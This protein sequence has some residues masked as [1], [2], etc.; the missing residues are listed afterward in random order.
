MPP[1]S[2]NFTQKARSNYRPATERDVGAGAPA[3]PSLPPPSMA[4]V[5]RR[6]ESEEGRQRQPRQHD[7]DEG[8]TEAPLV[9]HAEEPSIGDRVD[10]LLDM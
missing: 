10:N 3:P 5:T 9:P 2:A 1:P 8:P 7:E 6:R 4:A